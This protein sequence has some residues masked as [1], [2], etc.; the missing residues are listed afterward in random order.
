MMTDTSTSLSNVR[1]FRGATIA[2][3]TLLGCLSVWVL[4]AEAA[5]PPIV[6]LATDPQVIAS[7]YQHRDAAVTAARIGHMRGDL[8][9]EAAFAYGN[10]LWSRDQKALNEFGLSFG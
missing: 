9:S 5:R 8:W 3:A 10:L 1:S 6:G 7:G 2:Y 4:A